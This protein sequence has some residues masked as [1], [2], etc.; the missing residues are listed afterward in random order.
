M[1]TQPKYE[2]LNTDTPAIICQD[3]AYRTSPNDR[4]ELASFDDTRAFWCICGNPIDT[5]ESIFIDAK[6]WRDT[7]NGQS[8]F[9]A[10]VYFDGEL[11]TVMPFQYGYENMY[12]QR[13]GE[14]LGEIGLLRGTRPRVSD[15]RE[16]GVVLYT[17]KQPAKMRDA[18]EW[19]KR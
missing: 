3:C 1:K 10:R 15:L 8:Y 16:I 7:V 19:G 6:E 9:S 17:S 18:K 12:L 14:Y 2:L 5:I 13:L 4:Q 11:E